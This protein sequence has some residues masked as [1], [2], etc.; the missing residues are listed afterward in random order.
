M[1]KR[2]MSYLLTI[3]IACTMLTGI[4]PFANASNAYVI[5]GVTVHWDDF[6]SSPNDCWTYANNVYKK[7]WGQN[8]S[9]VFNDNNN[10]LRNLS[11]SELTLTA[12]HLKDYVSNAALGSCLR[13]CNSEY[14]HG[15]DN[16]GH[17]QII[18]QKDS[19]GFTV[20]EGGLTAS[21]HC[22]EKYYT[23]SEYVNTGWLGGTYSY[24]KYIKWPG[25]P[26]YT[27]GDPS[28]APTV[29]IL[30]TDHTTYEVDE[31]VVFS[32]VANGNLNNLWIYCPNGDTLTYTNVG[33]RY[34][35]AFGMSGHFQA[36]VETWNGV[37]SKCSD[38]I[39]FYVGNPTYARIK[40]N[41]TNYAVDERVY[42]TFETDG[43]KNVLWIYCPNGDTL[44]YED[45]GFAYDL[46]FG[47]SGHFQALVQTWNGIGSKI[48]DRIDFY[49]GNQTVTVTFNPNGGSVS[50]TTKTVTI[51][52]TYGT[53][54]TPTRTYYN[55]DGWYTS[56]SGGSKVTAS[57]T[58]TATTNH[59]LYAHWTHVC[60]NGHNYSYSVTTSP[61]TNTAG[62]LTG[63]CS[64]CNN[65]TTV[66]LPKL[67]TTD[68]NYSVITTATCTATG[69][70]RY[71]WK[72]TTYGSY[73]FDVTIPNTSHSYTT[74]VT[75]PTCTAQGYTTHTCSTCGD[76]YK[77][78]Y[79]DALGH[80]WDAGTV[81]LEPTETE[82]G[83]KTFTC[84]RCGETK[85]ESIPATGHTHSYT[86]TVVPPTCTER[87]YTIHACVCGDS[88]IDAYTAA[89]G[90]AWDAGVVTTK[91]TETATGIMTYT[92]T[93][94]GETKTET[95][96]MLEPAPTPSLPCDGGDSCPGNKFTDMPAKGNW[97]H[98]PIDWAI[99]TGVTSGTSETTFSPNAGCTRAQVVTF[100]WRAAGSPEPTS[101]NNPF[102]DVTGGYYYKAVLW[103]V[104]KNITSGTSATSFSPNATC[105][106][107]QI[108]TFL[109]RF[110]GEPASTTTNNPFTDVKAG[111]Y[112]EKAV[113][114][115]SE[116]GVTAGTS[117]TTFSPN[118]TCTRAQVVTFL[119]RDIEN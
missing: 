38:L 73:Y 72:T 79:T 9:S 58:V 105:T 74:T 35:L 89:L 64:R 12:A 94:C 48:S 62:T 77:D 114:W 108:V 61:T 52:S 88:Y 92:C 83:V 50:P 70:G 29:S 53:L 19:S 17:S 4:V 54:P 11:D 57:T 107:A 115:A 100:L 69:I 87:G 27:T 84:T 90:H 22:R 21:P 8:F 75:P 118:A 51:G 36:L 102:T 55:F 31:T 18:V 96:P 5:N 59:T 6:T 42:F 104:E 71:T 13:I 113:L 1:K 91:P 68:Y 63:T 26:A 56:A 66:T 103:A 7:I 15:Y 76:S 34:E 40:T 106:R 46:G 101:T 99:V 3:C 111:A 78:S 14:L 20:F 43:I 25:A 60:A 44:T 116:T 32:I 41:K 86:E 49:V 28:I 10:S 98:D 112:Y 93:R 65:T 119:Y 16:W 81:T 85:T 110:E 109:W 37:G 67:N 23:W 33:T 97:A 47:M 80:S 39:D 2:I 24:I 117:A 45:V 82:P 30:S 95:I